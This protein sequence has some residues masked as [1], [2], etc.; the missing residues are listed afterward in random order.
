[1]T[2]WKAALRR[3]EAGEYGEYEEDSAKLICKEVLDYYEER[4]KELQQKP[5]GSRLVISNKL[6]EFMKS[7][8][9]TKQ[10]MK[11]FI[12]WIMN[13][14]NGGYGSLISEK[15]FQSFSSTREFQ[16]STREFQFSTEEA[17]AK[18]PVKVSAGPP[19]DCSEN[20]TPEERQEHTKLLTNYLQGL[21]GDPDSVKTYN[22]TL[23]ETGEKLDELRA[24]IR[25]RLSKEK[26]ACHI[27]KK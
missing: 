8:S 14:F 16:F 4:C 27:L 13:N 9:L 7:Y 17:E 1:M 3:L 5:R 22:N 12:D 18:E 19:E 24:K 21:I 2:D 6:S 10:G 15:Q 11:A 20:Q 23:K 26:D 25:A